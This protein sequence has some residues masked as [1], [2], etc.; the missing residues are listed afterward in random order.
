MI[1]AL[2]QIG[3]GGTEIEATNGIETGPFLACCLSSQ[4]LYVRGILYIQICVCWQHVDSAAPTLYEGPSTELHIVREYA[5]Y[6][7]LGI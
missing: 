4:F 5:H 2:A 1:W 6:G 3:V 7:M